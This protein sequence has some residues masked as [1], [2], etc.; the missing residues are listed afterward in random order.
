MTLPGP[1]RD[2]ERGPVTAVLRL[3]G[4]QIAAVVGIAAVITVIAAMLSSDDPQVRAAPGAASASAAPTTSAPPTSPPTT[5]SPA[6]AT[7]TAPAAPPPATTSPVPTATPR[8]R[9]KV[10]VLNQSAGSG[11]A[12][13]VAQQLRAAGWRIGR[14]ADFSGNVSTTTV[15]WLDPSDQKGAHR[16]ARALG[17]VRVL[18]GFS[19]LRSGRLSVVLVE[20]P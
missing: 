17:G 5:P 13:Q 11:A 20:R 4:L 12:G 1:D 3:F 19:T 18:P 9:L 8:H 10:D 2:E 14:V 7:S 6:P 15:Y 16:L